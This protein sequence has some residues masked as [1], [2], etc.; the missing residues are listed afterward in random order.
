MNSTRVSMSSGSASGTATTSTLS[1][2]FIP[3]TAPHTTRRPA[4]RAIG[5]CTKYIAIIEIIELATTT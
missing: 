4:R 3:A 5:R 2:I 1:P